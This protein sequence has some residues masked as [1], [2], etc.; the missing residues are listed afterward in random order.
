MT[1]M[2]LCGGSS[3]I[4]EILPLP[5]RD[6]IV[7]LVSPVSGL[8]IFVFASLLFAFVFCLFC[9]APVLSPWFLSRKEKIKW[10]ATYSGKCAAVTSAGA[11]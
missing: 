3:T 10:H 7:G 9:F 6:F 8:F 5:A 1:V 11:F 4:P 2:G